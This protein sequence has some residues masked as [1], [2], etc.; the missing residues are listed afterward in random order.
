[1]KKILL[2]LS[3]TF[4]LSSCS[5]KQP[6]NLEGWWTVDVEYIE[7]TFDKMAHSNELEKGLAKEM[8]LSN[9]TSMAKKFNVVFTQDELIMY[10]GTKEGRANYKTLSVEG[11][12]FNLEVRGEKESFIWENGRIYDPKESKNGKPAMYFR[13]MTSNEIN[14]KKELIAKSKI[15]PPLTAKADERIRFLVYRASP[16]Q[17]KELLKTQPDLAK[18]GEPGKTAIRRAVQKGDLYLIEQ[19]LMSGSDIKDLDEDKRNLLF[20]CFNSSNYKKEVFDLLFSEGLDIKQVTN[21]NENLLLHY[22]DWPEPRDLEFVKFL[23]SKGLDVNITNKRKETPILGALKAGWVEASELLEKHGADFS[24]A[25]RCIRRLGATVNMK[26]LKY[27]MGR[28]IIFDEKKRTGLFYAI[29]SIPNSNRDK[30]G[31]P[32]IIALYKDHINHKDT[33]GET[34]IFEAHDLETVKWLVEAGADKNI[35]NNNGT[36]LIEHFKHKTEIVDYLKN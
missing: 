1:M 35:R 19:L 33:N 29:A 10:Y 16:E 2:L 4:L 9:V 15:A 20:D 27:L 14:A 24:G 6:E 18:I 3:L 26:T 25:S 32:E 31:I 17:V 34:A 7:E 22:C 36:S 21:E 28:D 12:T 30:K 8:F 23:I 11:N 5:E 13:K